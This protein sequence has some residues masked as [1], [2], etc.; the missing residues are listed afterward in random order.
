MVN[1]QERPAWKWLMPM[2]QKYTWGKS[3]SGIISP[4]QKI[5]FG[6]TRLRM[7]RGEHQPQQETPA[8][9]TIT[10][11]LYQVDLVFRNYYLLQFHPLMWMLQKGRG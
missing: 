9:G 5:M 2:I 4:T 6:A 8:R 3:G 11:K 7:Q 1:Y 10:H